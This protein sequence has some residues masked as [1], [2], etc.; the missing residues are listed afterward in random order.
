MDIKQLTY[1]LAIAEEGSL[2][3][4]AARLHMAQ[5][6]LSKYLKMLEDELG[7]M[8]IERNTR[9]LRIT[10]AG[11]KMRYRAK[12]IL[13]LTETTINELRDY[14]EGT[15]GTLRIGT[16]A[17]S[18]DTLLPVRIFHF[19]RRYPKVRFQI[20][21]RSTQEIMDML[22]KGLIDIGIVR[23]PVNI[24]G[25]DSILLPEE[26]MVAATTDTT[27]W[28]QNQAE[29]TLADLAGKPL[30]VHNRYEDIIIKL[31]RN[32]G[33]DPEILG[34]IDDARSILLWANIGMG[35]AVV[36]RDWLELL[37]NADLR[38]KEIA[39]PLLVTRNVVVWKKNRYTSS[40]ACHFLE[41]FDDLSMKV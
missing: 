18:G 32:A 15:H 33:F 41:T 29:I 24:E 28:E 38:Y 6:P 1:F 40:I 5:P 7:V 4:A 30:L 16:I 20:K 34:K 27:F 31:C 14:D 35:I 11:E 39:E 8:L 37:E 17:S 23:T 2:T 26:P 22:E 3:K 25:Y 21:E 19:H 12:Q 13:E 9:K 10:E 36:Q